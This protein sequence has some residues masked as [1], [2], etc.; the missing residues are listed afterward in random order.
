M[1]LLLLL[2]LGSGFLNLL[3]ISLLAFVVFFPSSRPEQVSFNTDRQI[4]E[5]TSRRFAGAERRRVG[6]GAE[7]MRAPASLN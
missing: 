3:F 4:R 5:C 7:R 1:L 2:L 6:D